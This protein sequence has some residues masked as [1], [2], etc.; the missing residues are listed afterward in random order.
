MHELKKSL[1]EIRVKANDQAWKA[2]SV[3]L[4]A[5]ATKTN[6]RYVATLLVPKV[7]MHATGID[8][9]LTPKLVKSRQLT[10]ENLFSQGQS[11]GAGIADMPDEKTITYLRDEA[12]VGSKKLRFIDNRWRL[13][14]TSLGCD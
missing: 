7:E 13:V 2:I 3:L 14:G 1:I 8:D 11:F 12:C 10:I 4:C 9:D 6:R 5:D